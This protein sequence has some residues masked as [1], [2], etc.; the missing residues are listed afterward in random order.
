MT[1]CAGERT[2]RRLRG[3]NWSRSTTDEDWRVCQVCKSRH[4]SGKEHAV[5]PCKMVGSFFCAGVRT[6]V[7]VCDNIV[8]IMKCDVK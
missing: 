1:G 6:V 7:E 4:G 5:F 8:C 3:G 2:F